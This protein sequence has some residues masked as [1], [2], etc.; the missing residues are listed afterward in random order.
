WLSRQFPDASPEVIA[1]FREKAQYGALVSRPLPINIM[2]TIG[3]RG[4]TD[5]ALQPAF[6]LDF[7]RVGFNPA[8]T[9]AIV[10]IA[11]VS[12]NEPKRSY[13]EYLYLRN[14][15]GTWKVAARA[16]NWSFQ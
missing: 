8:K 15:G 9:E 2:Q 5:P 16:R 1:D 7:S 4:A 6:V 3:E 12:Q 10:Y 13:G 14:D 11:G